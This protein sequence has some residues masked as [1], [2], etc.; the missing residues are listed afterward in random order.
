MGNHNNSYLILTSM[1]ERTFPTAI[2]P[3][4]HIVSKEVQDLLAAWRL[5]LHLS[6]PHNANLCRDGGLV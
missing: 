1:R 4:T 2:H 3:Y 6:E 5:R